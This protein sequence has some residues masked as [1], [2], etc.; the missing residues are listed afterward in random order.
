MNLLGLARH[1]LN[2][3]EQLAI[4]G[5]LVVAVASLIYAWL[6]RGV[7][8]KKDIAHHKCRRYGTPSA[9]AR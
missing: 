7:V 1:G 5:V 2:D 8:L 9:P 3:F 4:I 6:L